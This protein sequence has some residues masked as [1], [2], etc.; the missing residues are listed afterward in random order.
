MTGFASGLFSPSGRASALLGWAGDERGGRD[1]QAI[2]WFVCS[3]I[4]LRDVG[5]ASLLSAS[6]LF[7]LRPASLLS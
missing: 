1:R 5:Y 4:A 2:D 6:G 7:G 3:D